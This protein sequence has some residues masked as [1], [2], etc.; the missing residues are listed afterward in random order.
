MDRLSVGVIF[1]GRSVEHDVSIV[2]AHQV[3]AVIADDHDVVPIYVTRE[4]RW[5]TGPALNDLAVYRD[6]RWAEVGEEAILSATS[7][8]G[9]L[10]VAGGRLRGPRRVPVDV[11]IPSIHGTN[12]EDGTLQGSLDLADVPYSGSGVVASAVGMDKVAM[13]ACFAAAGLPIVPHSLVEV[14][15]LR[16]DR[17]AVVDQIEVDIA[18]PCFVKPSRLGSSVGIGKARDRD[19]LIYALDVASRYDRK[20]LVETSMEGCVEINCSVIG[21]EGHEPEAS[22]C[23]QP[24]AWEEFLTFEDKYLRAGKSSEAPKSTGMAGLERRIPAPISD[25]LTKQIQENALRAFK[26]IGAAGVARIDAFAREETGE[27]WVMEINTV[28]GSFSFYLWEPSGVSFKDLVGRLIDIARAEHAVKSELMFSFDSDVLGRMGGT[29][30][31]G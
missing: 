9:G 27:T 16:A 17:D 4:G 26:A 6:K 7:G 19:E 11:F 30:S 23:E 20:L 21:G 22:V 25:A 5:L 28:P 24:V 14:A 2:T 8:A 31:G 13:K 12:G 1:G 29:K 10:L 3:M 18:Y 15:R